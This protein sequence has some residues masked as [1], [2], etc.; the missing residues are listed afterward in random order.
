MEFETVYAQC[1][2]P[3]RATL[4]KLGVREKDLPDAAQDVFAVVHRK[5]GAFEGRSEIQTWVHGICRRVA[6]DYRRRACNRH[7]ML[8]VDVNTR[9]IDAF[10]V[11]EARLAVQSAL[12]RLDA[13]KR[14]VVVA[15][16]IDES[17]MQAIGRT[18]GVPLQTAYARLYAGHRALRKVFDAEA[19]QTAPATQHVTGALRRVRPRV[20]V[21][22]GPRAVRVA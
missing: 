11:V 9:S 6:A 19:A 14:E 17:P 10:E 15:Y 3:V 21:T 13:R 12:A 4:L 5:L 1:A 22:S 18:L 8:S 16:A 2:A 7:E 20:V